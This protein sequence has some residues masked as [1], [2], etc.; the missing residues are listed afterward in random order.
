MTNVP[1][2]LSRLV[3]VRR[4]E[5]RTLVPAFGTLLL[6]ITAHTA[7]ET[8]RDALLIARFPA[9]ELGVVYLAVAAC[10]LPASWVAAR[11]CQKMG[12]RRALVGG[13]ALATAAML[14][15]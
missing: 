8:A 9:G 7:L 6:L 11:V 4:G 3:D 12:V 5:L 10:V 15:L 2:W 1:A 14:A 13:L